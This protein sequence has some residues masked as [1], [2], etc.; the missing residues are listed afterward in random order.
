MAHRRHEIFRIRHSNPPQ[1][2][3]CGLGPE[4]G[5]AR[6]AAC[7]HRLLH[8]PDRRHFLVGVTGAAGA[9]RLLAPRNPA[10]S[11]SAA[12]RC[13]ASWTSRPPLRCRRDATYKPGAPMR[14]FIVAP[15]EKGVPLELTGIVAGLAC[16]PISGAHGRV[17]AARR[18]RRVRHDRFQPARAATHRHRRPLSSDHNHSRAAPQ[19]ARL[20]SASTW[21]SN[22]K[23]ELWTAMF[24]PGQPGNGRDPRFKEELLVKLGGT[25]A[26]RTGTFDIRLDL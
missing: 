11:A 15:G 18:R 22:N 12:R 2:M 21:S 24:F 26:Q 20:Q 7:Y 16:G 10:S 17:L 1:K 8:A 3:A 6:P 23:A 13:R 5:P 9:R 25:D 19:P 14:T 4:A